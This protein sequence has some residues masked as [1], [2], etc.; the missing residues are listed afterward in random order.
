M[1]YPRIIR[2]FLLG[3]ST[4]ENDKIRAWVWGALGSLGSFDACRTQTPST[5]MPSSFGWDLSFLTVTVDCE[6]SDELIM[7]A[8]GEKYWGNRGIS[9]RCL[10]GE[11]AQRWRYLHLNESLT[12]K[13][14][15]V[16]NWSGNYVLEIAIT[17]WEMNLKYQ[18][19][20]ITN[21]SKM[22]SCISISSMTSWFS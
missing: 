8:E 6:W 2:N 9:S 5:E 16:I 22:T 4:N 15:W 12:L 7:W 21:R 3:N 13:L 10:L 14:W 18:F 11:G 17:Q 1:N 19:V 20:V